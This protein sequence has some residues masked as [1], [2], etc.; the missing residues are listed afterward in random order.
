[1][2]TSNHPQTASFECE[3]RMESVRD[4][5]K[6]ITHFAAQ[7][8]ADPLCAQIE[9]ATT[10]AINNVIEHAYCGQKNK[11]LRVKIFAN[12]DKS[13]NVRILDKGKPF[14]NNT[15]PSTDLPDLDVP[16]TFMPEGSFGWPLIYQVTSKITYR[17]KCA[18]N[19][20]TL[21]FKQ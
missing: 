11:Y 17:R 3:A 20:L 8:A 15:L 2:Q 16:S 21:T 6:K 4:L 18:T 10:E 1:M 7:F 9:I 12:A 13:I 19:L 5:V 14:P